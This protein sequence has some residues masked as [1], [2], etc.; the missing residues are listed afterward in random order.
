VNK[1]SEF[2]VSAKKTTSGRMLGCYIIYSEIL[3]EVD[4]LGVIVKVEVI[5]RKF[6]VE[7]IDNKS[8]G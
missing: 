8:I 2:V 5:D 6:K 7:V 1:I 3:V 4:R